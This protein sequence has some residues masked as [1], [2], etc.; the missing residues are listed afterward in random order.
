MRSRVTLV[1]W[2]VKMPVRYC[3]YS[4]GMT[5]QSL[6]SRVQ[7]V[8]RA[9]RLLQDLAA[10]DSSGR[11]LAELATELDVARSTAHALLR[12]L[13]AHGFVTEIPGPRFLLGTSLIRLGDIAST[14]LPLADL[15]RPVLTALSEETGLTAR[16]AVADGE[17][18][19]FVAR[20]DGPGAVRFQT[21]LGS[22]EAVHTT[23][24]GK[25]I[26]AELG[27]DRVDALAEGGDLPRRTRHSITDPDVLRAELAAVRDRGYALDDEED[28]DGIFCVGAGVRDG[29]GRLVGAV[30]VS[31]IKLERPSRT[32]DELG[33]IVRRH[34]DALTA[35][36]G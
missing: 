35:R 3:R 1:T 12:T 19:V 4:D 29:S 28:L 33:V 17:H 20:V 26:L 18:P 14:Q 27:D 13:E 10:A 34:A 31:G 6:R 7:S 15:A 23:A 32:P 25:I 8:D 2:R 11:S 5:E 9:V 30:S 21:P 36:L 22:R 24:A 16:F